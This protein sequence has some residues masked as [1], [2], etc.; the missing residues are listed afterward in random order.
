MRLEFG[1]WP[2]LCSHGDGF[3]GWQLVVRCLWWGVCMH[4][5]SLQSCLTLCY[6]MD[7]SWPGSSV[8]G[9]LQARILEW[10]ALSFYR[11]SSW[12]RDRTRISYVSCIAGEFFTTSATGKPHGG[13]PAAQFWV[14]GKVI[15]R[16]IQQNQE[17]A[18][19][20]VATQMGKEFEG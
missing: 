20:Y 19:Y 8:R 11:G 2:V 18:Q 13:G 5:K 7:H 9:I 10:V 3:Q 17:C 15:I 12:P 14:T 6:T 4:A 1:S 16:V